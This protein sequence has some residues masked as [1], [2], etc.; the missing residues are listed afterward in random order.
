MKWTLQDLS[1]LIVTLL[2]GWVV[3]GMAQS[4]DLQKPGEEGAARTG[5]EL[6]AEDEELMVD[7]EAPPPQPVEPAEDDP[8]GAAEREED[9]RLEQGRELM[10]NKQYEE[11]IELY[12][13][14][15]RDDPENRQA[16]FNLSTAYIQVKRHDAAMRIL[17]LLHRQNPN[18][19]FIKNNLA[20]LYATAPDLALRDGEKAIRL[21]QEA[22]LLQP[23]DYHVWSTLSEAHYVR[24][25]YEKAFRAAEAALQLGRQ[26]DASPANIRAY[27]N[28]YRK[29]RKAKEAISLI[30]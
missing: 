21:A 10:S 28:Q 20:W 11:A 13:A 1:C 16:A 29:S 15:L 22:L 12:K 17:Q 2:L 24:G 23:N 4:V 3:S 25:N 8:R 5:I 18:D 27:I 9:P 7:E 26:R 6:P 30:D 19:Y 14:V